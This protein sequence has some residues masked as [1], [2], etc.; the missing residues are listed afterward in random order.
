MPTRP[1]VPILRQDRVYFNH[2]QL[3]WRMLWHNV[4]FNLMATDNVHPG[5]VTAM[6]SIH[7]VVAWVAE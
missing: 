7:S 1:V 3:L 2:M 4:L 5:H 6:L